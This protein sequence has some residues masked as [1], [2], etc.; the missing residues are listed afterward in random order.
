[1]LVGLVLVDPPCTNFGS[2]QGEA[3]V[4]EKHSSR[5]IEGAKKSAQ[6]V[7][8]RGLTLPKDQV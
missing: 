1:M 7:I 4:R 6:E 3:R 2:E 8:D 5:N